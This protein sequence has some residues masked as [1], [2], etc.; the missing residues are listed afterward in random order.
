MS[1]ER[2]RREAEEGWGKGERGEE[3]ERGHVERE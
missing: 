3:V 1:G 2:R